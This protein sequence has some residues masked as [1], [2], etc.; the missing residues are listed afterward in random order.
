MHRLPPPELER[1][2]PNRNLSEQD[3]SIQHLLK[4]ESDRNLSSRLS[5][6][7]ERTDSKIPSPVSELDTQ[8]EDGNREMNREILYEPFNSKWSVALG[9]K[10]TSWSDAT[11]DTECVR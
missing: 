1:N 8:S 4:T 10:P 9:N 6:D 7:S 3:A 11:F 2:F 5:T